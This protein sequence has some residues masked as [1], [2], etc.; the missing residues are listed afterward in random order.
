[1]PVSWH[2]TLKAY[3]THG[4]HL[5]EVTMFTISINLE[6]WSKC[7][8]TCGLYYYS[9]MVI[10]TDQETTAIEK[11]DCYHVLGGG[12]RQLCRG[13]HDIAQGRSKSRGRAGEMWTRAFHVIS[14]ERNRWG[15][16]NTFGLAPLNHL[17]RLWGPGTAPHL[18]S[19]PGVTPTDGR[20][21]SVGADK[22]GA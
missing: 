19:S 8:W 16:V 15:R 7:V 4:H 17:S 18:L 5:D 1:M 14:L 13:P 9:S 2:S 11:A 20:S 12:G 10:P 3:T 6:S 22:G 21:L